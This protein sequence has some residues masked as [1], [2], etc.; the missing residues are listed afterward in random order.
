[1]LN[2]E[3]ISSDSIIWQAFYHMEQNN[4]IITMYRV[5]GETVSFDISPCNTTETSLI[6]G[7]QGD[8]GLSAYDISGFQGTEEEWLDSLKGEK[9]EPGQNGLTYPAANDGINGLSPTFQAGTITMIAAGSKPQAYVHL[10]DNVYV[11]DLEIPETSYGSAGK[12][13]TCFELEIGTVETLEPEQEPYASLQK[14]N[15]IY[16]LNI[17]IPRGEKGDQGQSVGTPFQGIVPDIKMQ[18][19]MMNKD[20]EP[21]VQQIVS[22]NTWTIKLLIPEG[23]MPEINDNIQGPRGYI[24]NEDVHYSAVKTVVGKINNPEDN[25]FMAISFIKDNIRWYGW[26]IRKDSFIIQ[27]AYNESE[28]II[29]SKNSAFSSIAEGWDYLD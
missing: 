3:Q 13:G 28:H 27:E 4:D 6:S 24:G 9:G 5:N 29:R 25:S 10:N 19:Q 1:M 23:N 15:D 8:Q 12:D 22:G 14:D 7:I 21:G 20:D 17:G 16:L 11:I 18:V 26:S 2:L